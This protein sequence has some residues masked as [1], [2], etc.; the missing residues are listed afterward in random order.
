M[1]FRTPWE[2]YN[3][4][5]INTTTGVIFT[6][7]LCR[8]EEEFHNLYSPFFANFLF[9]NS[10]GMNLLDKC[11]MHDTPKKCGF[12]LIN[13]EVDLETCFKIEDYSEFSTIYAVGSRLEENLEEPIFLVIDDSLADGVFLLKYMPDDGDDEMDIFDPAPVEEIFA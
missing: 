12:E 6:D 13:G 4:D 8:W 10:I 2:K 7:T 3:N 1:T 11:I 9:S 5:G